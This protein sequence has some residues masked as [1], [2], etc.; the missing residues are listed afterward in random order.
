MDLSKVGSL[1]IFVALE[2]VLV[3]DHQVHLDQLIKQNN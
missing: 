3:V 2:I 1:T